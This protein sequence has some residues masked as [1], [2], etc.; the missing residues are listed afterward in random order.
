MLGGMLASLLASP[1]GAQELRRSVRHLTWEASLD[2][3]EGVLGDAAG[4]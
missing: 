1:P 3:L 4:P 2:A